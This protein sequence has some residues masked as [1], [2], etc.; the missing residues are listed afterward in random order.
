MVDHDGVDTVASEH[1]VGDR[2][3]LGQPERISVGHERDRHAT[4]AIVL[5]Q[6]VADEVV[7]GPGQHHTDA[8]GKLPDVA[9]LRGVGVAVA[10]DP[11]AG[12]GRA[13]LWGELFGVE[14]VGGDA[15]A[16]H[17]ELVVH[18]EEVTAGVRARVGE[19]VVLRQVVRQHRAARLALADVVARVGVS[20]GVGVVEQAVLR[21]KGVDA[22]DPVVQGVD[23]AHPVAPQGE[24]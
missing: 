2:V 21:I 22:V 3:V 11:V 15:D 7:V 14:R 9:A 10:V 4:V 5:D 23:V 1:V 20:G 13:A 18:D 8:I 19:R 24:V 16:V 12:K 17:P 6:V